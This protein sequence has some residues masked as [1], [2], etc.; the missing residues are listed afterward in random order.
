MSIIRDRTLLTV[1]KLLILI[2]NIV[3]QEEKSRTSV[4]DIFQDEDNMAAIL[5]RK[6]LETG[7]LIMVSNSRL[8]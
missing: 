2:F 6:H 3:L 4:G 5:M 1:I 8:I 7:D